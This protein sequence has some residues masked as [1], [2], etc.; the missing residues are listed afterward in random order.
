[1]K[2]EY[3]TVS[4]V[5]KEVFWFK[6]LIVELDVMPSDIIVLHCDNNG[7]IALAKELRSH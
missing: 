6:K 4:K 5:A 2:V 1:M 7:A 3:I